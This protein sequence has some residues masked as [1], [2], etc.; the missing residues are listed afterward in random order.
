MT[1]LQIIFEVGHCA[2]SYSLRLPIVTHKCVLHL[3]FPI[4]TS[5]NGIA[6]CS[7]EGLLS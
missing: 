5:T 6:G 3:G 7:M 2:H 1:L 4:Q